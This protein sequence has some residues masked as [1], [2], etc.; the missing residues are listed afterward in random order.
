MLSGLIHFC[1]RA[2]LL[3][4]SRFFMVTDFNVKHQY[5]NDDEP[6]QGPIRKE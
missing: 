4:K 6:N 3:E 2:D 5:K 1:I